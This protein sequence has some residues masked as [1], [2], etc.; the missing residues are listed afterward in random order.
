MFELGGQLRL[1]GEALA[2]AGRGAAEAG[3]QLERD[4]PAR[5][6]VDRLKDDA[7]GPLADA[8]TIV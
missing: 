4:A 8:A 3:Q 5:H 2:G 6:V 7:V 1:A